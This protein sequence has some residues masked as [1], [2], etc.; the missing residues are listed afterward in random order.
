MKNCILIYDDDPDILSVCKIILNQNDYHVETRIHN[1][2]II[3]DIGQLSPDLIFMDLW[4]PELGG[5]K[6]IT[7]MKNNKA[8]QHIPIILFSANAEIEEIFKRTRA[9]GFLKKPFEIATLLGILKENVP[10]KIEPLISILH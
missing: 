9:D 4:I 5:E 2:D 10:A 1:T 3:K 8:T 7:L 6:A